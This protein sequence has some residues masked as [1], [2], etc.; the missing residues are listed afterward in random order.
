MKYSFIG[1][2]EVEDID[3]VVTLSS[4]MVGTT[5]KE[6]METIELL[7]RFGITVETAKEDMDGYYDALN[8]DG[9]CGCNDCNADD[10]ELVEEL[11]RIFRSGIISQ[12]N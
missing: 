9:C 2:A 8:S 7:A 12:Q 1:M 5:D 11:D 6:V 3:T 4:A 10:S